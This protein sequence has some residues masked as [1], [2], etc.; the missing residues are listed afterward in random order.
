MDL[1]DYF[2]KIET[3]TPAYKEMI[4]LKL[5]GMKSVEIATHMNF[6]PALV[7]QVLAS[8]LAQVKLQQLSDV[9]D[10]EATDLNAMLQEESLACVETIVELRD[11]ADDRIRLAAAKDILDRAGYTPVKKIRQERFTGKLSEQDLDA[12]KRVKVVHAEV[13][14]T[15][16]S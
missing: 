15:E 7:Q 13:V 2:S 10:A 12:I 8:P 11:A 14:E 5:T 6:S 9:K 3:L 4:R 16:V 1:K